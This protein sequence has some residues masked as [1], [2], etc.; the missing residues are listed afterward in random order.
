MFVYENTAGSERLTGTRLARASR[1]MRHLLPI[2]AGALLA[3]AAPAARAVVVA[4]DNSAAY[5]Q[6]PASDD[7]GF[8][9]V[10]LVQHANGSFPAPCVYL[11]DGWLITAFHNLSLNASDFIF[12]PVWIGG[13]TYS[14][15]PATATRLHNPADN[16]LADLAI[17]R[18]TAVPA[19][20][21]AVNLAGVSPA[22]GM[23]IRMIGNGVDRE[24]NETRWD[25]SMNPWTES[26]SGARAGYKLVPTRT[27]RWGTNQVESAPF[28]LGGVGF[29]STTAFPMDFDR[30]AGAQFQGEAMATPG[31]SGGGV[32][33]QNGVSWELAGIMVAA[34]AFNGQPGQ[35]VAYGNVTYAADIATYRN[36]IVATM[37][38]EPS[39][40]LCLIGGAAITLSR[41]RRASNR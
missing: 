6:A 9:S 14:P 25:P 38:P 24:L 29:G 37:V 32:F 27:V 36:E 18:L 4:L 7:F 40:A 8:A 17:F 31:D 20:V 3:V 1:P 41:R 30:P 12:G 10:G 23:P 19:G 16:S 2:F 5:T 11:G 15:D 22:V 21:P 35:T 34:A 28:Q 33:A 26:P 39:G 13:G